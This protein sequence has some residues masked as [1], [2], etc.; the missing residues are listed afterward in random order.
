M[1]LLISPHILEKSAR[2]AENDPHGIIITMV[3]ICVVFVVLLALYLAY[4]LIGKIISIT[5]ETKV[6]P[7][8]DTPARK[9]ESFHDNESYTITIGKQHGP[10]SHA[11]VITGLSQ[12]PGEEAVRTPV[13]SKSDKSLKAPLPGVITSIK[14]K[15]GDKVKAGQVLA[16][17]EAMKMENDLESE[18]DGIVRSIDI[19]LGE[20]V[21]EGATIITIA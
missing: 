12:D 17:L 7:S 16:T 4:T 14:V 2:M 20:S 3:S 13:P 21:L 11:P 19:S 10:T 5:D 9:D 18:S 6:S 15:V 1:N 8:A